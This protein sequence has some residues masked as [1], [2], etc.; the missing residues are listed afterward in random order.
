MQM[1]GAY[2]AAPGCCATCG[3]PNTG[4]GVLDLEVTD[5]DSGPHRV[6]RVYLC[7]ECALQ[8][9]MM[10]AGVLGRVVVKSDLWNSTLAA[11]ATADVW[12]HRYL[13]LR[14]QLVQFKA[15]LPDDEV[16]A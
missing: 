16:N 1:T 9:G 6:F 14:E 4:N 12:E 11:A 15:A 2:R 7:G 3:T 10:V 13:Q 8:A 5:R